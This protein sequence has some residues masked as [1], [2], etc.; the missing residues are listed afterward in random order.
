[1]TPIMQAEITICINK[2][3]NLLSE[4][5]RGE[6]ER[7]KEKIYKLANSQLLEPY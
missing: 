2:N 4:L 3:P 7:E 6:L 5:I 1:M